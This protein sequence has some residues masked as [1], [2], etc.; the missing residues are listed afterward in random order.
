MS[1]FATVAF[2]VRRRATAV[3]SLFRRR[4]RYGGGAPGP[5]GRP[6]ALMKPVEVLLQEIPRPPDVALLGAD[7]PD[8]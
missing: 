3:V 7:V 5:S 2:E 4:E 1:R 6:G 8:G